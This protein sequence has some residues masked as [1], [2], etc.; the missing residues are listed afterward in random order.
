M[1][2]TV[3]QIELADFLGLTTRTIRDLEKKEVL[4]KNNRGTYDFRQSVLAYFNY[5]LKAIDDVT[6]LDARAADARNKHFQA[7]LREIELEEKQGELIRRGDVLRLLESAFGSIRSN[8]LGLGSKLA[9]VLQA[10][11]SA[12]VIKDRIDTEIREALEAL[13]K[14]KLDK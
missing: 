6:S 3:K 11:P 10:Q 14:I 2:K 1:Q 7:K 4:S 9:P 13:T 8:L 5:K 12:A